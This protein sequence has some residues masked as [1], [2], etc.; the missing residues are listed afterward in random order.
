MTALPVPVVPTPELLS[1]LRA[2]LNGAHERGEP[3]DRY[4]CVLLLYTGLTC[5]AA[6]ASKKPKAAA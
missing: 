3:V 5:A 2:M 6:Q 4:D 1:Q